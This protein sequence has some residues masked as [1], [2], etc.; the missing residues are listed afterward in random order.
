MPAIYVPTRGPEDWKPLLAKPDKHWQTGR[1][2]KALAHCWEE[3]QGFPPEVAALFAGSDPAVFADMELLLALPEHQVPLPGGRR[4]SQ[5]DLWCLARGRGGLVSLAVEGK[6]AESF[7]PT[8]EEWSR[9]MSQGKRVR[10]E[11]LQD[12]VGLA[13]DLPGSIRYQLLHRAACAVIEAQRFAAPAA[14]MLVHSFSPTREWFAD[15]AAF[16]GLFAA[17]PADAGLTRLG[18]PHGIALHAGWAA[19]NP[20]FLAV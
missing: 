9:D 7:G 2:A 1:S 20:R 12:R 14:V 17:S 8:L 4:N 13:G 6:V 3:A 5:N 19:G 16:L 10:L 11:F 15:Y 18:A